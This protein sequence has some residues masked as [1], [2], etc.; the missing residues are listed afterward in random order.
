M[1]LVVEESC[2]VKQLVIR[3]KEFLKLLQKFDFFFLLIIESITLYSLT[4]PLWSHP[5]DIVPRVLWFVEIQL[6][7]PN[8]MKRLSTATL[9]TSHTCA[10]FF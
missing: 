2:H 6:C 7:K 5:K 3:K 9:Q 10:V 1:F 8:L 4:S